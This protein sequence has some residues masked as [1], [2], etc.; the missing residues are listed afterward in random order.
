MTGELSIPLIFSL[1][2]L[3]GFGNEVQYLSLK[4]IVFKVWTY[5]HSLVGVGRGGGGGGMM[6]ITH[7]NVNF[8]YW[9]EQRKMRLGKV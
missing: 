3:L 7:K 4:Y 8:I 5:L 1:F 6:V 9:R 2:M